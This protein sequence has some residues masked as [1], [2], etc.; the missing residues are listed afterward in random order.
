[1]PSTY[2]QRAKRLVAAI[3]SQDLVEPTNAELREL[4]DA[5]V[6]DNPGNWRAFVE[7]GHQTVI[8]RPPNGKVTINPATQHVDPTDIGTLVDGTFTPATSSQIVD[9]LAI[10]FLREVRAP[11]VGKVIKLRRLRRSIT[12]ADAGKTPRDFLAEVQTEAH[13]QMKGVLGDP[14]NDRQP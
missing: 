6:V 3:H 13:E 11:L 8:P 5:V 4:G 1:M 9:M 2:V 12:A 14:A 10:F 7:G